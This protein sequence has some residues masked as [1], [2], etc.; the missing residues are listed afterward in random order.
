MDPLRILLVDDDEV[1]RLSVKRLFRQAGIEA[2]IRECAE[3]SAALAAAR[4]ETF[5]CVLLDYHLPGTD[6]VELLRE[7]HNSGVSLP[8]VALTGQGDEDVAVALMKAGAADYV[9]KNALSAERLERS[10]RYAVALHRADEERRLLLEREHAGPSR[11]PGRQSREG[12][13]PGDAVARAAHATE[14]HHGMVQ[15]AG[16]WPSRRSH[17]ESGRSRSSNATPGCK[18]S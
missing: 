10:L 2:E 15:A 16:E 11:S 1:D 9:N 3:R 18:H 14:C 12:R 6:G 7:L 5:D 17:L 8:V 4:S 13:I